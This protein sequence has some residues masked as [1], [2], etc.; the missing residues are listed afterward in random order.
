MNDLY[1]KFLKDIKIRMIMLNLTQTQLADSIGVN[2]VTMSRFFNRK[3]LSIKL[4][5]KILNYLDKK[6]NKNEE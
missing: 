6:E 2:K 5:D 1:D 4:I 3:S